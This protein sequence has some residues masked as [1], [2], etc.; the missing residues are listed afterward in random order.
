MIRMEIA[1]VAGRMGRA[2]V[3]ELSSDGGLELAC[4]LEY[5]GSPFIGQDAGEIAGTRPLD[6]PVQGERMSGQYDVMVDFTRPDGVRE[7]LD[8]CLESGSAILIGTSGLDP[9]HHD[10][11]RDASARIP[12]MHAANT[13]IG[14]N[15]CAALV[16]AASRVLGDIVDIEVVEAHHRHKIDAPSGTALFLGEAASKGRGFAFPECG[17][18]AREGVTGKREP[19]TIGF[20]TIRGGD[21]AGEHTVM[22]IGEK[23]RIEITH[24]A[25]DRVIFARGAIRSAKWLAGRKPGLYAMKDVLELD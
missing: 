22:F 18:F 20:S 15:L 9:A 24:R 10:M 12:V 2:I 21:I 7:H 8:M 16:E 11:I 25:I 4:A 23:E 5:P 17:V 1:G 19:D 6:I 14:V 13:S 3:R